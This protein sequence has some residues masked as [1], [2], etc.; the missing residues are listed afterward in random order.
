M[1]PYLI[2]NQDITNLSGYRTKAVA[3]YFFELKQIGDIPKIKEIQDFAKKEKLKVEYL[4]WWMNIFFAFEEFNWVIIKNSL[5]WFNYKDWILEVNSWE[6][7][8]Y[9]TSILEKEF[10]NKTLKPWRHL[11]GTVW[12]AIVGNAWCFWLEV[13]DIFICAKIYD[14]ENNNIFEVN[15]E[16]ID[17]KYRNTLFKKNK[18]YFIISAKFDITEEK[19]NFY[20]DDFRSKNQPGWYNCW[21]VFGNPQWYFAGKLIEDLGLKWARIG[22]AEISPKHANF[23]VSDW[24]ATYEDILNLISF[25]KN[26]VFEKFSIELHEEIN[27]ISN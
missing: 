13:A 23:I 17:F 5:K 8:I 22:W 19:D 10:W 7:V 15:K 21:S 24:T 27:I 4:W 11:P 14:L 1:L 12:W 16:F 20:T 9:L 26:L 6:N 2:K 25:I 18:K 3:K